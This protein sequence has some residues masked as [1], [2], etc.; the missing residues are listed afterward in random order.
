MTPADILNEINIHHRNQGRRIIKHDFLPSASGELE[1]IRL[2]GFD[3][4]VQFTRANG[5]N[6]LERAMKWLQEG[7]AI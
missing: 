3:D 5:A 7:R 1:T 4:Y 2:R 6:F